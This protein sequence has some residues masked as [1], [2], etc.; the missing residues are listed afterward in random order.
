MSL[1]FVKLFGHN[2]GRLL[3]MQIS[4]LGRRF[5]TGDPRQQDYLCPLGRIW[6]KT[7]LGIFY[8][9]D[10]AQLLRGACQDWR[11]GLADILAWLKSG[12]KIEDISEAWER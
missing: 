2:E 8:S 6:A 10:S 3:Q 4:R 11:K 12:A 5:P 9:G 7:W 1:Q